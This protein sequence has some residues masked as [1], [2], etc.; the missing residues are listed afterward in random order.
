MRI[1]RSN[2]FNR[3][4]CKTQLSFTSEITGKLI[5]IQVTGCEYVLI[6]HFLKLDHKVFD[7]KNDNRK[8]KQSGN[9]G[10]KAD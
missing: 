10:K 3:F 6:L 2:H 8:N 5:K 9:Q 1:F 4:K 7:Y